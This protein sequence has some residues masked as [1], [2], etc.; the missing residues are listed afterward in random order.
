MVMCDFKKNPGLNP[1]FRKSKKYSESAEN[2]RAASL[3]DYKQLYFDFPE[4]IQK[5]SS[6][7]KVWTTCCQ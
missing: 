4:G 1:D 2:R 3:H 5:K 6:E 7:K